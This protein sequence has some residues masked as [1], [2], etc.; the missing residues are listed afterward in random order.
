MSYSKQFTCGNWP[1]K[2]YKAHS[3]LLFFFPV[4]LFYPNLIKPWL[5]HCW[6]KTC[7]HLLLF[8]LS[9]SA[10]FV[11][12]LEVIQV[13]FGFS[14]LNDVIWLENLHHLHKPS[15]TKLKPI[16]SLEFAF[17]CDLSLMFLYA[18][19]V[20]TWVL[21]LLCSIKKLSIPACSKIVLLPVFWSVK[22]IAVE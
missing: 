22:V 8:S 3:S 2:L 21:A 7:N 14:L 4:H 6:S 19:L 11:W 1:G 18:R 10:V 9:N 17:S 20:I 5:K 15:D 16:T 13:C 12:V